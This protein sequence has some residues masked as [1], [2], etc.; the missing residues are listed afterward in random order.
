MLPLLLI[1]VSSLIQASAI[2][3][4]T[5]YTELVQ[6]AVKHDCPLKVFVNTK[7]FKCSACGK[8]DPIVLYVSNDD[9]LVGYCAQCVDEDME[10]EDNVDCT[11]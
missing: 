11:A 1:I 2:H 7:E 8:N 4:D 3:A 6:I 9:E 10:E 5:R